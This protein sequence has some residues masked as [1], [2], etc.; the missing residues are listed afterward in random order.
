MSERNLNGPET[1]LV[2]R[3][4]E[5]GDNST[6]SSLL[7]RQLLLE[8]AAALEALEDEIMV[9]H[10]EA[11]REAMVEAGVL[12]VDGELGQSLPEGE[13]WREWVAEHIRNAAVGVLFGEDE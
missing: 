6:Q 13:S 12:E 5:R 2:G 11:R 10:A 7:V 8:A 3:L 4:R 1:G 9:E